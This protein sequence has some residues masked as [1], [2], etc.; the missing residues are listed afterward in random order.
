MNPEKV[1]EKLREI[2]DQ[3]PEIL[4]IEKHGKRYIKISVT[5]ARKGCENTK[6]LTPYQLVVRCGKKIYCSHGC[7]TKDR[8]HLTPEQKLA[9]KRA[10]WKKVREKSSSVKI[11]GLKKGKLVTCHSPHCN[12]KFHL[13]SWQH[14]QMAWCPMCRLGEAYKIYGMVNSWI[15]RETRR[16]DPTIRTEE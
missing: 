15:E 3:F 1:V 12:H 5:C 13:E 8:G 2:E 4:V 14:P 10:Y 9:K 6:V 16:Q 7:Y 11:K